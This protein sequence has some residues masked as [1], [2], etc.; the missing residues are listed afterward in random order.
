MAAYKRPELDE[1]LC[2][3]HC[4]VDVSKVLTQVKTVSTMLDSEVETVLLF[5]TSPRLKINI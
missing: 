3:L 5:R 1:T 2:V 4:G